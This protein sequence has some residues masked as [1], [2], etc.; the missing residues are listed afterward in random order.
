MLSLQKHAPCQFRDGDKVI[1]IFLAQT[2]SSEPKTAKSDGVSFWK[3]LQFPML[4]RGHE[5]FLV[6]N[7]AVLP[8][9]RIFLAE[10]SI[11]L[12][13]LHK[14]CSLRGDNYEQPNF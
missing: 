11:F 13:D 1:F 14:D 4:L 8:M 6:K 9:T 3:I 2:D 10:I 12:L 5:P 7:D